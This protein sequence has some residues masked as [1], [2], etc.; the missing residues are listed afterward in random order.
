M[1]ISGLKEENTIGRDW[2]LAWKTL[3]RTVSTKV[4]SSIANVSILRSSAS[5]SMGY[6]EME[7][8]MIRKSMLDATGMG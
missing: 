4:L 3:E 8:N 2:V 1:Q 7:K 6:S 5:K